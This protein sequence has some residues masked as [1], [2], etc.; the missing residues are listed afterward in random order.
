MKWGIKYHLA[1]QFCSKGFHL[2]VTF[3][4]C[5]QWPRLIAV[6]W[7][8]RRQLRKILI[9]SFNI[10]T[11]DCSWQRYLGL[12][13]KKNS[14]R[15]TPRLGLINPERREWFSTKLWWFKSKSCGTQSFPVFMSR[16]NVKGIR[17]SDRL[18]TA[19]VL[20]HS[21]YIFIYKHQDEDNEHPTNGSERCQG[22]LL[23]RRL[24]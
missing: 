20:F 15:N 14:I 12:S 11:I 4:I 18:I 21:L 23:S 17:A 5:I 1:A 6:W 10:I 8:L 7:S 13:Y 19:T 2:L 9:T 22:W 16:S 3:S 24:S